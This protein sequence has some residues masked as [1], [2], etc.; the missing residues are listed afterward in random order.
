MNK[1]N[2]LVLTLTL[3]ILVSFNKGHD[4]LKFWTEQ[5]TVNKA[6][7]FEKSI[8]N[9]LVFIEI[10]SMLSKDYFPFVDNYKMAMPVM[11]QRPQSGFL[12]LHT[13]YFFSEPDSVLRFIIYDWEKEKFGN[14]FKKKELWKKESKKLKAYNAEY[15][16]IKAALIAQ[17][18]KPKTQ[19]RKPQNTKSNSG[20]PDYLSRNTVWETELYYSKLDLIFESMTYRIRWHYYWKI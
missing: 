19:D 17:L 11:I 2:T 18:G 16:K 10:N 3:F 1:T 15:K 14:F 5:T 8:N 13:E 4:A 6:I 12:P 20:G 7:D 9:K